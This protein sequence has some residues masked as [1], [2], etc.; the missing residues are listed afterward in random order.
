MSETDAALMAQID[1]VLGRA[2]L[3]H[4]GFRPTHMTDYA[5]DLPEALLVVWRRYGLAKL[6][7]GRLS[8]IDPKRLAGLVAYVFQGDPDLDGDMHAIAHGN[9]GEVVLWSR[10]YGFGLLSPVLGTLEMPNLTR[11]VVEPADAQFVEQVVQ[12]M[13]D[14]LEAYDPDQMPV[15]DR[16]VARLGALPPGAI[17]GTT[18]AP[19]PLGGTRVEDY[20]VADIMEWLEA[21]YTEMAVSLVDWDLATP[22]L[23]QIGQPW[24]PGTRASAV[25]E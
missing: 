20:V 16:L 13:P 12:M 15:H 21:V 4:P 9:L 7:D 11:S 5:R 18:P 8:L 25:R 14:V 23:R 1:E 10:R 17:Y 6:A 24:A 22:Q 2:P 19:P 3:D